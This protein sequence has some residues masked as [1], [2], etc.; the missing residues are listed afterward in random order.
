M[1]LVFGVLFLLLGLAVVT[2]HRGML[3]GR[4]DPHGRGFLRLVAYGWCVA[5]ALMVVFGVAGLTMR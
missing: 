4:V 2:D 5:G 3:D 1:S